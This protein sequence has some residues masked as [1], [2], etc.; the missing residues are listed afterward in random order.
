M[1][2]PVPVEELLRVEPEP[3]VI[4]APPPEIPE[5]GEQQLERLGDSVRHEGD[6]VADVQKPAALAKRLTLTQTDGRVETIVVDVGR[7]GYLV[8]ERDE[9]IEGQ[10]WL[11]EQIAGRYGIFS[12]ASVELVD[13]DPD[14]S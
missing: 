4:A 10:P 6:P 2:P 12:L 13:V 14:A 3:R 1:K 11:R 7:S 5:T 9:P 8:V